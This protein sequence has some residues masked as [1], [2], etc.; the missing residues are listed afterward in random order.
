[1]PA[2]ATV[3]QPGENAAQMARS[4]DRDMITN[5]I[6]PAVRQFIMADRAVIPGLDIAALMGRPLAG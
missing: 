1:M 2:G 3:V 5:A 4:L 6:T